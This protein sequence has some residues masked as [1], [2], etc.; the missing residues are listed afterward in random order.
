MKIDDNFFVKMAH[1]V[2]A[3]IGKMRKKPRKFTINLMLP[4]HE[5]DER[6]SE[7]ELK[8]LFVEVIRRTLSKSFDAEIATFYERNLFLEVTR[9]GDNYFFRP[10]PDA[11]IK[12]NTQYLAEVNVPRIDFAQKL[13]E[14]NK[15]M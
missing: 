15:F 8:D 5:P 11:V 14:E 3:E 10:N 2:F 6:F 12:L 7:E 4:D 13:I 9:D 1:P